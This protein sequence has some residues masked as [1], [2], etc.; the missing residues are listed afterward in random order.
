[1]T[2]PGTTGRVGSARVDEGPCRTQIHEKRFQ[3]KWFARRRRFQQDQSAEKSV[4]AGPAADV[5]PK[6]SNWRTPAAAAIAVV[7]VTVIA[8]GDCGAD[9]GGANEAGRIPQWSGLACA[10]VVDAIAGNA[11][12]ARAANL[13]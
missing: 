5:L 7:V 4:S 11:R 6:T 12:V 8:G 2:S 9:D 10:W 13:V 3:L 1:M